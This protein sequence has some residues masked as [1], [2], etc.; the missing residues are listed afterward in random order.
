[1]SFTELA[2]RVEEACAATQRWLGKL[3]A[4]N[5]HIVVGGGSVASDHG[6][7]LL[8]EA[9]CVLHFARHLSSAGVPWEN[10]HLELSRSKLFFAALHPAADVKPSWRVDLAV[11]DRDALLAAQPPFADD[12]FRFDAFFEFALAG[13]FWQH[14]A[15]YGHPKKLREKVAVDVEKVGR[16][17]EAGLCDRAYVVVF[18][19]CD[20]AFPDGYADAVASMH[21]GVEVRVLRGW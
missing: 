3:P 13:N 18:E 9:D 14:G 17:L 4:W 2:S 8:S 10:M 20:H 5:E 1:M 21:P 12:R 6:P 11:V 15:P 16:Y 7:T 19:E